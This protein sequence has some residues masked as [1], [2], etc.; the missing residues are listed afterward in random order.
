MKTK[1]YVKK[2]KLNLGNKFNHSE[3][4]NDLTVDFIT[5]LEVGN[6]KG[7]LKGFNNAVNA[8]RMKYDAINNKTVG[9]LPEK[10]W[11]FFFAT[12][13]AK[14]RNDLFPEEMEKRR[15][16]KERRKKM[17]EDRKNWEEQM[18]GNFFEDY[19]AH[20]LA[21]M[22]RSIVPSDSFAILGLTSDSS[23]NDVKS[24]YKKLSMQHHPDKG[25]DKN[26]FTQIT[27]AKNKCLA[28]LS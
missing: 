18:Y 2:F 9:C 4:V 8:I 22:K 3:F 20:I 10:L 7:N 17:Y 23:V 13:V 1:E 25:G 12:V 15:V 16:E 27:D 5:L 21:N 24:A 19:F 14:M 6:G 28:Y 11:N 26:K